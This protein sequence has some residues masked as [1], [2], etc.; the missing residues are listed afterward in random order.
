[1]MMRHEIKGT[2]KSIFFVLAALLLFIGAVDVRAQGAAEEEKP[3]VS[4]YADGLSQYIFR[5]VAFSSNS[6]VLQ[7]SMTVS[8]KGLSANIWG[9][10]DTRERTDN[11]GVAIESPGNANWNETDFTVS[12]THEL[13]QNLNGTAGGVYYALFGDDSFEIFAG[14]SYTL[15]WF[16][17]GVTGY[18]EVS[19]FPGW[20]LQFDISRNFALP[21]YDMSVDLGATFGFQSEDADQGDY[22][23]WHNAQI[24][25]A[26]NIPVWKGVVVSP[27]VGVSTPLTKAAGNRIESL[28]WDGEDTHV[29]GGL[30]LAVAF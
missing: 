6:F 17:V 5:G 16:T 12:Y 24:L 13:Y 26:L 23:D 14:L 7:P 11:S 4:L 28:S 9:N 15:P 2:R 30:R 8:Y 19:H 18:R 1:M 10:F 20:W 25:A 27:R 22:E 3:A 29:F 21:W